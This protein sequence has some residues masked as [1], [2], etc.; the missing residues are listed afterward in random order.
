MAIAP[1]R[2]ILNRALPAGRPDR[3]GIDS[4]D[5]FLIVLTVCRRGLECLPA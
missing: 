4:P 2:A 5:Q 1:G 3:Q